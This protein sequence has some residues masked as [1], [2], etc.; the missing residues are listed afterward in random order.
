MRADTQAARDASKPRL[1]EPAYILG[2]EKRRSRG[3]APGGDGEVTWVCIG[4]MKIGP[5]IKYLSKC[6]AAGPWGIICS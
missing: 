6:E 2:T 4:N 1:I 3:V 5:L